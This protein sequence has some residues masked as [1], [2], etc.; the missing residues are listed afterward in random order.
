MLDG[1][2]LRGV[3]VSPDPVDLDRPRQPVLHVETRDTTSGMAKA[4]TGEVVTVQGQRFE[5]QSGAP[6]VI[7]INN[8]EAA[9]VQAAADGTFTARIELREA[10]GDYEISAEQTAARGALA[11]KMRLKVTLR[12]DR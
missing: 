5:P 10:P 1:D 7:R 4:V 9:R 3:I 12:D 8:R 2:S 6:I 11:A